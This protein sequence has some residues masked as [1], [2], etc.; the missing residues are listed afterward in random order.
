MAALISKATDVA[1]YF[2]GKPNPLMMR[3]A[4]TN[5]GAAT[6]SRYTPG[7]SVSANSPWALV[8]TGALYAALEQNIYMKGS[9]LIASYVT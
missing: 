8:A 5:D 4:L 3:S 6:T 1:P 7:A 2:V 9:V